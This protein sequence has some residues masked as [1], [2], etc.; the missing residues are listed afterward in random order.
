MSARGEWCDGKVVLIGTIWLGTRRQWGPAIQ[1]TGITLRGRSS[2]WIGHQS[3]PQTDAPALNTWALL[4]GKNWA[5][6]KATMAKS[7]RDSIERILD[8]AMR[9]ENYAEGGSYIVF[10]F[11]VSR[12]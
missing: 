10:V 4:S 11:Q 3:S 1:Y 7:I 9:S 6:S 12:G 5:V 8:A 2:G